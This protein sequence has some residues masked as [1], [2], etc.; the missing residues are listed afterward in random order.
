MHNRVYT[1]D[2]CPYCDGVKRLLRDLEIPFEE[3]RVSSPEEAL[4]LKARFGWRTFP[5]VILNGRFVGGYDQ[6]RELAESGELEKILARDG[7]KEPL[8]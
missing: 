4:E 3:H 6:M 5:M 1:I 7:K 2:P 8:P